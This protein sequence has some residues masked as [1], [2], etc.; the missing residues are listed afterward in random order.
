MAYEELKTMWKK[1]AE[2][3]ITLGYIAPM[4]TES[5]ITGAAAKLVASAFTYPLQ[6]WLRFLQ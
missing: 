2:K 3:Y 5:F 1:G 4:N 6:V